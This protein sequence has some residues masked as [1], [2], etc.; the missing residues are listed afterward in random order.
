MPKKT[1]NKSTRKPPTTKPTKH[2]AQRPDF[3]ASADPYFKDISPAPLQAAAKKLR[4]LVKK[5]APKATEELKW[6]HPMY[7]QDGML[8]YIHAYPKWLRFGFSNQPAG[9]TDPDGLMGGNGKRLRSIRI[10]KPADINAPF[11]T[12][13]LK[14]AIAENS[15]P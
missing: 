8:C 10:T 7:C 4:A 3:G 14:Q 11:L 5:H 13:C 12:R 2:Y 9:T 6:G 1:T 15:K